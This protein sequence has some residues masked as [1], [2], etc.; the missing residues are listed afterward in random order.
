MEGFKWDLMGQPSRNLED[1]SAEIEF[2][3]GD[4][5]Y[6]ILVKIVAAFCPCLKS[7]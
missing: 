4:N 1:I 6:D 7:T 2:N 5:F 3:S